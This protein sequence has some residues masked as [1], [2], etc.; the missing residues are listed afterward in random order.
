MAQERK[1]V[2]TVKL[3]KMKASK[4]PISMV[5]A[6]DYLTAKLADEAGVDMILIGDSLG[7]V[8]Q[9][10]ESTLPVTLDEMIYH[11]KAVTRAVK[12][13][14]V[15]TD[16]PF[17]TY[18]G[19]LDT[20]LQNAGRI[21]REG[22]SKGVKLEG[23]AEIAHAVK[24]LTQAGVPVVGHLG[25]TPQSVH[26]LGGYRIQG[27]NSEQA[28]KL[29]EDAKALEEAGAIAI[30]LELVT[31]ELAEWIT[32]KLSIPTIGIGAGASCDGQVLVFHD[33]LGYEPDAPAKKFVKAYAQVG[34]AI[35]EGIGQYVAE[36]KGRK[37]PAEQHGFKGDNEVLQ[38]LYGTA[39]K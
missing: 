36:V 4:E 20:T 15:V 10:H 34:L 24:A 18:H 19:S 3:Q 39:V 26:V 35:R 12:S 27:K 11:T 25:L 7:N 32:S 29:M 23:G 14:F 8:I 33:M 9:G 37:F 17:M 2:T 5:T 22:L 16:L 31:E 6:Y 28:R 30:V 13:A 1:P 38:Y 21:M